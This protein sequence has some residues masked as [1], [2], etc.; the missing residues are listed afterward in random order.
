MVLSPAGGALAKLL[1]VF[2]AGVGGR[3]GGGKQWMSWVG[4]DDAIGAIHHAIMKPACDGPMNVVTP[5]PVTNREFAAT[6]ARV[7]RRPAM[8]PVPRVVLRAIF[9]E[10]ADGTLLAS[11]RA[12]PE[13]LLASG[14][15]F[16]HAELETALRH[17]CGKAKHG[18]LR[19]WNP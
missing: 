7:L 6:L 18:S 14:Y 9:G 19:S 5:G 13:S 15:R 11:G 12:M 16:R 2:R 8:V 4:I 17:V 10:M 1:P 3:L